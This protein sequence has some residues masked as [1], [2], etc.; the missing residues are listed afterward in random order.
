MTHHTIEQANGD[1]SGLKNWVRSRLRAMRVRND[2]VRN[3]E[4]TPPRVQNVTLP[5]ISVD[6]PSGPI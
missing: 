1:P 5:L 2:A 6:R 3:A 4:F